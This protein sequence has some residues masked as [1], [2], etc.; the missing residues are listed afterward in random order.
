ME[1]QK[2]NATMYGNT[3]GIK[4]LNNRIYTSYKP[5]HALDQ[6]ESSWLHVSDVLK[7]VVGRCCNL[8]GGHLHVEQ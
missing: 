8:D 2:R 6:E 5:K 7:N 4:N 3:G 1:H